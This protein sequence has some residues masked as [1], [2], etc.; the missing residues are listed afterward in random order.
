MSRRNLYCRLTSSR[1]WV[2]HH[3]QYH[4]SEQTSQIVLFLQGQLEGLIGKSS[5]YIDSLPKVLRNRISYL[6]QLQ[7]QHDE[8]AEK[9]HEEQVALKRKYEKLWGEYNAPKNSLAH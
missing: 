9:L 1:V 3:C 7:D 6:S 4:C 5:G 2:W 8:L